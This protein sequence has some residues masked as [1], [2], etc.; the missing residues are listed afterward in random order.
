MTA[1]GVLK[2]AHTFSDLVSVTK[3]VSV[4]TSFTFFSGGS[5]SFDT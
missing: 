3:Y 4:N 5:M 1:L 2:K